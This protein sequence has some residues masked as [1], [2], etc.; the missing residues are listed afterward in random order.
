MSFLLREMPKTG[1]REFPFMLGTYIYMYIYIYI[2]DGAS[3]QAFR[4]AFRICKYM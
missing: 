3:H 4:F 1:S 2:E